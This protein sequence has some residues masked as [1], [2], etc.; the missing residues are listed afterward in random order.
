MGDMMSGLFGKSS[1]PTPQVSQAWAPQQQELWNMLMPVLQQGFGGGMSPTGNWYQNLDPTIRAGIEEPYMRGFEMLGNQMGG[2]G[3]NPRAGWSGAAGDVFGQYA[4]QA[5]QGMAQTGW[6]MMMQP[7]QMAGSLLGASMPEN[8]VT[9]EPTNP[10]SGFGPAM[11]G[12]AGTL[13][14][15]SLFGF[16]DKRL[17]KNIRY[18]QPIG[19]IRPCLFQYI[20]DKTKWHIGVIAQ[21]LLSVYPEFVKRIGQFYAVDYGELTQRIGR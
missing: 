3:G 10:W 11:A 5:G 12:T 21:D 16:S 2:W 7:Y 17:K 4:Q 8:I 1:A 19:N 20:W 14:L 13:G 9:T 18:L 6:N 15:M